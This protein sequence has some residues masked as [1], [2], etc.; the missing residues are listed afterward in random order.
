M[1]CPALM[2]ESVRDVLHFG[3]VSNN[4]LFRGSAACEILGV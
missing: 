3:V 1:L 2:Q 4:S